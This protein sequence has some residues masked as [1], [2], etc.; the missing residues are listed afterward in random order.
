MVDHDA[1]IAALVEA[2]AL[3][4]T[5][6]G[7]KTHSLILPPPRLGSETPARGRIVRGLLEHTSAGELFGLLMPCGDGKAEIFDLELAASWLVREARRRPASEV[8]ADFAYFLDRR[9]V[10]GLKVNLIHGLQIAATFELGASLRLEPFADVPNSWQKDLFAQRREVERQGFDRLGEPI[11]LTSRF[12]VSPGLINAQDKA[13]FERHSRED[14]DRQSLMDAVPL[15]LTILGH[16]APVVSG[17]WSQVT[18]RGV[19]SLGSHEYAMGLEDLGVMA[20]APLQIDP[21][22]A[23]KLTSDFLSLSQISRTRLQV[24]LRHLNRSRRQY[25][26]EAA[27]IDLRTA[28]EALLASDAGP[29]LTF[30]VSLL[31]AWMLGRGDIEERQRIYH[32]LR[33]AYGMGSQAVHKGKIKENNAREI[34]RQVQ[35]DAATILRMMIA[36]EDKI[37]PLDIALGKPLHKL[38]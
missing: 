37:N 4:T 33:K 29:E 10:E 34:V 26:P 36:A 18:G 25:T 23:Q 8:V 9:E 20:R 6:P 1:L 38:E 31:G 13:T 19:P 15:L 3:D 21:A 24:P 7:P 22:E 16:G 32:R 11:A 27:A 12:P 35:S 17:C 28:L 30:R 14:V 5:Y 2:C